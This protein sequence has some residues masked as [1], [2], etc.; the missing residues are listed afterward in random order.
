MARATTTLLVFF[1]CFNIWAG[2]LIGT[3]AAAE[4][5]IEKQT[6]TN[7]EVDGNGV[8]N[9]EAAGHVNSNDD[10]PSG[11]GVG[12]TLFGL[13]NVLTDFLNDIFTFIAP[14]L[15]LLARAGV[16]QTYTNGLGIIFTLITTID[17][18]SFFKGWGL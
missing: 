5:G 16:P 8:Q 3:G 13:Y 17:I 4:L 18:V 15:D 6:G 12:D 10:V 9:C 1:I 14:G 11:N 2:I 7:C